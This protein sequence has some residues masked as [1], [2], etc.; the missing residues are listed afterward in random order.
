MKG[1]FLL[2]PRTVCL[3]VAAWCQCTL[4]NTAVLTFTE[5]SL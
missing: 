5:N 3:E 1:M 4:I 2:R